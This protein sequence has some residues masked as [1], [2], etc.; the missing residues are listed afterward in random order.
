MKFD[1][2]FSGVITLMV[3]VLVWFVTISWFFHRLRTRHPSTYEAIGSPSLFWNNSMRNNWLFWKFLWSSRIHEL[4]DPV[5]VRVSV[6]MRIWI[7]SY[8]ILFLG[9]A[10]F[11]VVFQP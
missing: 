6:F 10:I 7:V 3:M 9:L 2:F 4:D 11:T 5:A 8:L 1:L